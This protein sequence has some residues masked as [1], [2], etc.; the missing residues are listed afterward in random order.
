MDQKAP[1]RDSCRL[2]TRH[3]I[4]TDEDG[5]EERVDGAGVVGKLH[6]NSCVCWYLLDIA[7][8]DVY[9]MTGKKIICFVTV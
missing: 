3:W 2:E 9:Y 1:V 5:V 6:G 8:C 4:I 7:A